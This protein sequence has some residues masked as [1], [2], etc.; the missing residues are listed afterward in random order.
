MVISDLLDDPQRRLLAL[1]QLHHRGHEVIVLQVLDPREL[2]FRLAMP[3]HHPTV[4]RDMETG[5]E[6]EAEPS[7]VRDLVRSEIQ[8]FLAELDEGT[9]NLGM[10]L[11]RCSTTEPPEQVLTRYLQR[12]LKGARSR[13]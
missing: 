8:R 3:G 9:R 12:R 2:D 13:A 4:I 5:E 1:G 6:F 11:V 10:H 7:L